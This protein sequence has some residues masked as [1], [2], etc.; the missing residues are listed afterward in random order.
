VSI[1]NVSIDTN[2]YLKHNYNITS[3]GEYS[4]SNEYNFVEK[5]ASNNCEPCDVG[6]GNE[7][8]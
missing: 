6:G 2:I 5:P 7:F 1:L 8:F 3:A 4:A